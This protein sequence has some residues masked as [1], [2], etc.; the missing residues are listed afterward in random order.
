MSVYPED[1]T[2]T[3]DLYWVFAEG[4][5]KKIEL[6]PKEVLLNRATSSIS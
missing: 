5:G 4:L 2:L 1:W 6:V 3:A